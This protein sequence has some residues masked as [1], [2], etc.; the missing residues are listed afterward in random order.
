MIE[1]DNKTLSV[2][3]QCALLE[4][5][6]SSLFYK[7]ADAD[8]RDK[9]LMDLIDKKYLLAPFLGSRRMSEYLKKLGYQVNRKRVQRLMRLMGIEA[10][11][12]K[13]KTS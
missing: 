2:R 6:R 9:E 5:N 4:I 8:A 11:Y 1:P 10:I 12:T 7:K 3:R 13:P